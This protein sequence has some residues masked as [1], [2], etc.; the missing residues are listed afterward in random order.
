MN[1]PVPDRPRIPGYNLET[2]GEPDVQASLERVFGAEQG[3]ARWKEA[4]RSAGLFVGRIRGD[5]ELEQAVRALGAQG[6]ASAS[7][8]RSIE[9][10]MRTY[11]R[12]AARA[13]TSK[14]GGH[15]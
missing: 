1:A 12:L 13:A 4:C 8:A 10:R 7:V 11:A 6:G 15:R 3:A 2:P 9:I 14:P 5:D